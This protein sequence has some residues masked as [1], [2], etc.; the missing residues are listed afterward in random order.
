MIKIVYRPPP[1][2]GADLG[3]RD[4]CI[5]KR[6]TTRGRN[7]GTVAVGGS[8]P[9]RLYRVSTV[10]YLVP[11]LSWRATRSLRLMDK[12]RCVCLSLTGRGGI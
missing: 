2:Y 5:N 10:L 4:D 6:C 7:R 1:F 8:I 3:C 9:T 12:S 11:R